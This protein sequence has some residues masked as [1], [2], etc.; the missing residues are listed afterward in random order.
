MCRGRARPGAVRGLPRP[1]QGWLPNALVTPSKGKASGCW[2]RVSSHHW[3]QFGFQK[4]GHKGNTLPPPE[5]DVSEDNQLARGFLPSLPHV[6]RCPSQAGWP[7]QMRRCLLPS[8]GHRAPDRTA[9][10]RA[11]AAACALERSGTACPSQT[12]PREEASLKSLPPHV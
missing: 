3:Q 2:W 8:R 12:V 7:L 9:R 5:K 11:W 10:T 6:N 4:L 1:R